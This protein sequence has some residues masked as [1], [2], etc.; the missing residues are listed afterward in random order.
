MRGIYEFVSLNTYVVTRGMK[1]SRRVG[2]TTWRAVLAC[3]VYLASCNASNLDEF[4]IPE[5]PSN[6]CSESLLQT[7]PQAEKC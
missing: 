7:N 2:G 4:M 5:I 3:T 6:Y 1:V